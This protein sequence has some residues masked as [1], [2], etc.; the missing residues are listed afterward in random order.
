M[1]AKHLF[2]FG[3]T[4]LAFTASAQEVNNLVAVEFSKVNIIYKGIDNPVTI[5]A[6]G[7]S[8]EDLSF[9]VTNGTIE[10]TDTPGSL[11]IKT[12]ASHGSIL[13]LQILAKG[14]ELRTLKYSVKAVPDPVL[15]LGNHKSGSAVT[16]D[17][18]INTP[19]NAYKDPSFV[20]DAH[21]SVKSFTI[22]VPVEGGVPQK[23]E[24]NGN[25]IA[26]NPAAA[27]AVR[28]SFH[29]GDN[30]NFSSFNINTPNG[31]RENFVGI[32]FTVK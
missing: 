31:L 25:K 8:A 10:S 4:I 9:S 12:N 28:N 16:V 20:Y 29:S 14:T 13:E 3:L 21:Y 7:Y 32:A 11:I 27:A 26:V 2:V 22:I 23:Y 18:L 15:Q 19:I 24:I 30:I 17:E 1:K 6:S 5:V